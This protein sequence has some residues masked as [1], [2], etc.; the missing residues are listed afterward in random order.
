V[1]D[2]WTARDGEARQ[3]ATRWPSQVV[4]AGAL[5]ASCTSA[6]QVREAPIYRPELVNGRRVLFVP[7]ATSSEFGDQ[8]TDIVLSD[9]ARLAASSAAC[10]RVREGWTEGRLI[11]LAAATMTNTP[12]LSRAVLLYALDQP[13][14]VQTWSELRKATE[15]ELALLFRP[16]QTFSAQDVTR[17]LRLCVGGLEKARVV[18][19]GAHGGLW[20]TN[21]TEL[22][23]AISGSLVDMRTGNQL[24]WGVDSR[25]ASRTVQRDLGYAEGPAVQPMLEELMTE[26]GKEMLEN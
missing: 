14:P 18:A 9:S 8:R 22:I 17:E 25:S 19:C 15:A 26:L 2:S 10:R 12:P 23:Y 5:L 7:L 4:L 21:E 6:V 3:G 20:Y 11:C 13:I 16:E 1:T 24:K